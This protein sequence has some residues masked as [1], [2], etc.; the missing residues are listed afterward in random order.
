MSCVEK[1]NGSEKRKHLRKPL[2]ESKKIQIWAAQRDGAWTRLEGLLENLSEFGAGILTSGLLFP[3]Q[4]VLIDGANLG[5]G[6]QGRARGKVAWCGS[7]GNG[8]YRAGL[9]MDESTSGSGQKNSG[10]S[11]SRESDKDLYEVLE[12]HH[13][14]QAETIHRVYRIMAQRLHPD[15]HDTGSEEAFKE[16]IH[17]YRILSDPEQRAAYDARRVKSTVSRWRLMEKSDSAHSVEFEKKK[18]KAVLGVLYSK[19]MRE[20]NSHGLSLPE[21]EDLLGVPR[22]HL[23][24]TIWYLREQSWIARTDNGRY[25]V[26]YKGV[27]QAEL[28]EALLQPVESTQERVLLEAAR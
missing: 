3:G 19:R 24:F 21:L 20:P 9:A 6:Q 16:L 27:E 23:E 12:V 8:N 7:L 15:N 4:P 22:E 13:A 1:P 17:A 28:N 14:A 26:T 18:R 11:V 5:S 25:S 10:E 2:N